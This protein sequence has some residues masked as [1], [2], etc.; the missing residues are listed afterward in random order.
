MSRLDLSF[1]C[2]CDHPLLLLLLPDVL[3]TD[4]EHDPIRLLPDMLTTDREDDSLLSLLHFGVGGC[5]C[6]AGK[7]KEVS[8]PRCFYERLG[9]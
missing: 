7:K 3:T 5:V 9:R 6:L 4:R 8:L 2:K 1:H